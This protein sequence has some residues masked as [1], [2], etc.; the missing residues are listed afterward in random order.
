MN[1]KM[2]F[3]IKQ[4]GGHFELWC[5]ETSPQWFFVARRSSI[6]ELIL[7]ISGGF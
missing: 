5:R 6:R 4:T 2:K 7:L 1:D 3:Q